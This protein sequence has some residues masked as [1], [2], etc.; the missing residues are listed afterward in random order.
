MGEVRDAGKVGDWTPG[1]QGATGG[2]V[3]GNPDWFAAG[4]PVDPARPPV[5]YTADGLPT[6]C[7][8]GLGLVWGEPA[9]VGDGGLAWGDGGA[10]VHGADDCFGSP[11]LTPD[12]VCTQPP[13]IMGPVGNGLWFNLGPGLPGSPLLTVTDL[14]GANAVAAVTLRFGPDCF[15]AST[16][17]TIVAPPFVWDTSGFGGFNLWAVVVP[18]TTGAGV[19]SPT[20][21]IGQTG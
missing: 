2:H 5:L 19:L 12:V 6:C 11:V 20:F 1:P 16:W 7:R 4:V 8:P 18:A 21:S 14:G 15:S 3:C 13:A 9:N 17:G 10:E